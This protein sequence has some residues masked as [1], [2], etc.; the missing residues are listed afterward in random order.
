MK[1]WVVLIILS[2]DNFIFSFAQQL[3]FEQSS[4]NDFLK[5]GVVYNIIDYTSSQLCVSKIISGGKIIIPDSI[6]YNGNAYCVTQICSYAFNSP[7][8]T[9]IILPSSIT[10]IDQ[11]AFVDCP[12]LAKLQMNSKAIIGSTPIFGTNHKCHIF[13]NNYSANPN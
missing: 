8:V 4:I 7:E 9:T 12:M 10:S 5:D 3:S 1:R 11:Y 13:E 2:I 6:Y